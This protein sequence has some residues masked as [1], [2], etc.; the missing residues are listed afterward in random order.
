M[1]KLTLFRSAVLLVCAG[2]AV[3]CFAQTGTIAGSVKDTSGAVMPGVTVEAASPALIEKVRSVITDSQ[4][5]YKL[6]DLR[7][8]VYA[9]TFTLTGFSSVKRE[10]LELTSGMTANVSVELRVGSLTETV[11]VSGQSLL[12]DVQNTTQHTAI[13]RQALDDLPTGRQFG[14]YGVL[15][16]GVTTDTQDV[17]GAGLNVTTTNM[18]GVHG[19]NAFEMPMIIDGMRYGNIF[20]QSGGASGPYL[21]NNG[22]VE[23][24]AVDTSGAPADAEVGGFRANVILKQGGNQFSSSWYVG[25]NSRA[26]QSN[27]ID[28]ALRNR[29]AL[30]GSVVSKLWDFNVGVGGPIKKDKIWFYGSYRHYGS[31]QEPTGAYRAKDPN[32]VAFF[33]P[34]IVNGVVVAANSADLSNLPVNQIRNQNFNGRLVMQT[35]KNSKLSLYADQMPRCVCANGL[36][37]TETY[38]ATTHYHNDLNSIQ[39]FTW[40]WTV[41]SKLLVELGETFKPDSWQFDLQD[42]VPTTRRPVIDVA[43]GIASGASPFGIKQD[44]FQNNGKAV[45]TYVTGSSNLKVGG[46]W[47]HGHRTAYQSLNTDTILLLAAGTPILVLQQTTPLVS[48]ETLKLNL[49]LFA[50]EQYTFKRMTANLGLRF[51]YLNEYIPPQTNPAGQFA[52]AFSYPQINDIPNWKDISPRLG[53]SYDLAGNGKTAFKAYVGR[54]IEAQAAGFPQAVNPTRA[55]QFGLGIGTTSGARTWSDTNGNRAPDCVLSNFAANGECGAILNPSFGTPQASPIRYDPAAVNGWG[56]RQFNW[57]LTAGVQH[58]LLTGLSVDVS[59]NRRWFGN[60]RAFDAAATTPASYDPFC[61]TTPV[62]PR[63]PS[64]GGQPICGFY[65]IKPQFVGLDQSNILITKASN[66]GTVRQYYDGMDVAVKLRLPRGVV[67]QGGT[68]TGREITNWCGAVNGHPEVRMVSPYVNNGDSNPTWTQ[69]STAAPFCASAPPF[70]TQVKLSG[71]YPLPYG[72]STSAAFQSI[73]YPQE[74]YGNFGG[75]LAANAVTSAQIAPSLGRPLSSG[76]ESITLQM[77][78]AGSLFG[79]RIYQLDWRL[80]RNFNIGNKRIQPQLDIYNVTNDNS[81]LTMNNTYGKQWQQPLSI[82]QGRVIKF[83]LQATF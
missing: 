77:I 38:E 30:T 44:S 14:N 50:Q 78:P 2:V 63:L 9:V 53:V 32:Q 48:E 31:D 52:P 51:D 35:S 10:G 62:D 46:Q 29:G 66:F 67:L 45:V 25:G 58:E 57:E 42:G 55:N 83:G 3:P 23:E 18:M 79:D 56:V 28:D 73:V 75:I 19:S 47:F 59:Y 22:M 24:L 54:F 34:T 13:T 4:G 69:F 36:S 1:W 41:T 5:E 80:T 27:N 82:L 43:T 21:I 40:N 7:A 33:P 74:F 65:D 12:V 72:F 81:V 6:V 11:T 70:Q 71:V 39:Q 37:A 20:G 49:G 8:G 64:G 76:A 17:G 16:P 15:I 68:S 60:F 61:I 26:L